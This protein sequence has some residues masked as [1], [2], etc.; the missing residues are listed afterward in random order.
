MVEDM[1]LLSV[2]EANF[3]HDAQIL[4]LTLQFVHKQ[5]CNWLAVEDNITY[6]RIIQWTHVYDEQKLI[7]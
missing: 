6:M 1:Y 4:K 7:S 5:K 2:R 3:I